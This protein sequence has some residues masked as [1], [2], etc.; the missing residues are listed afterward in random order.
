MKGLRC[1]LDAPR[2]ADKKTGG[3]ATVFEGYIWDE[4]RHVL[5]VQWRCLEAL[6]LTKEQTERTAAD[7]GSLDNNSQREIL[8][9]G[10]VKL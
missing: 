7:C 1:L 6:F 10:V 8:T 2:T 4:R 5:R 3:I 9:I